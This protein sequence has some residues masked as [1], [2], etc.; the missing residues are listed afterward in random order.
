MS[1]KLLL[2]G[3]GHAHAEVLRRFAR[4]P[5]SN[6]ELTL[7]TPQALVPYTGMAPGIVSGRY[8]LTEAS[9]DAGALAEKAGAKVVYA[10]AEA[11]DAAAKAVRLDDGTSLSYDVLSID[12]GGAVVPPFETQEGG[13]PILSVK[14]VEP[15]LEALNAA[16]ATSDNQKIIVAGGGYGGIE[17]AA[18]LKARGAGVAIATGPDGLAPTAPA[19]ARAKLKRLLQRRLVHIL[20]GR[21]VVGAGP[22]KEGGPVARLD[23]GDAIPC[24]HVVLATGVSPPPL[25]RSIPHL[26]D[27]A[28]FLRVNAFLQCAGDQS[29]FAAGDCATV[30]HIDGRAAASRAGVYAVREGP[31]LARNIRAALKGDRL[32]YYEPQGEALAILS[33]HPDGAVSIR[34]RSARAGRIVGLLKTFIDRRFIDRYSLGP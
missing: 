14:P 16:F 28:G 11:I 12:V 7:V 25:L 27:G 18:A 19:K 17:L 33:F 21:S 15:F 23:D 3:A 24:S 4:R 22:D 5:L 13:P 34:G 29:I 9:I 1:K 30:R 8:A 6:A 20:D 2:L 10:K 32:R 31:V 26:T